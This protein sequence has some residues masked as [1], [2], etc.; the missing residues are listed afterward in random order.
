MFHLLL[1]FPDSLCLLVSA[2]FRASLILS[3][4]TKK[5]RNRP[6][7]KKETIA[8]NVHHH[9]ESLS[10]KVLVLHLLVKAEPPPK[11]C[12]AQQYISSALEDKDG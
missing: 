1:T 2:D 6:L 5:G 9:Y 7:G 4:I 11:R 10:F 8:L 12:S 3:M